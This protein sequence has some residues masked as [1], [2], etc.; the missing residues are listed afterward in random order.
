[1]PQDLLRLANNLQNRHGQTVQHTSTDPFVIKFEHPLKSKDGPL[2][3]LTLAVKDL[4]DVAGYPTL[5]GLK[6]WPDSAPKTT[7]ATL[8]TQLLDLG[9][10]VV[11]K[12][13][14][15]QLAHSTVGINPDYGIPR[16]VRDSLRVPGG[17]S[18]GSGSAVA[19]GLCHVGLGSDT[20][21]S[22]RIPAAY[23]GLWG[24][25]PT[26]G[27]LSLTGAMELAPSFDTPGFLTRDL[28]TLT[29]V[30]QALTPG[31]SKLLKLALPKRVW[32]F[33][34]LEEPVQARPVDLFWN[35]DMATRLSKVF[36]FAQAL[37]VTERFGDLADDDSLNLHPMI[38]ARL[39]W[40]KSVTLEHRNAAFVDVAD[41]LALFRQLLDD[42]TALV[43][44]TIAQ[45]APLITEASAWGE[46]HRA[47]QFALTSPAGLLGAPQLHIPFGNLGFSLMGAWGTDLDLLATA[48]TH[49]GGIDALTTTPKPCR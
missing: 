44:P 3:D 42:N 34:G 46:E 12:A 22:V 27:S 11:G 24:M 48:A 8:V 14:T 37:E 15:E 47:R 2:S 23:Q 19:L 41:D 36:R 20:G 21:G 6:K 43:W 4:F 5:N 9:I 13:V 33:Y 16:N 32:A 7:T 1:M 45:P 29:R 38:R 35:Q 28:P 10:S 31:S 39:V 25:R 26:L 30:H 18:S 17:S 49:F 40:N